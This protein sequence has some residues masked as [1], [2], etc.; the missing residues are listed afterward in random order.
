MLEPALARTC[1]VCAATLDGSGGG[2]PAELLSCVAAALPTLFDALRACGALDAAHAAVLAVFEG[3]V[4]KDRRE[5]PS[6]RD[7]LQVVLFEGLL[8]EVQFHFADT[9]PLKKFSHAAYNVRR[10][11]DY[12][13]NGF[14][15]IFEHPLIDMQEETRDS[16]TC[17]LH[18]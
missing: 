13:L 5:V 12:D 16:I 15:T 3:K 4:T 10:P 9:L 11:Q 2:A 14:T 7:V 17:K 6:C 18:F 1:T 8:C